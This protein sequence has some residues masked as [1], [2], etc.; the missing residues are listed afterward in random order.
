MKFDPKSA[1]DLIPDGEYDAEIASAEERQSKSGKDMLKLTLKVWAGTGGPRIVFDY[2]VN[3]DSLWRLKQI[4]GVLGKKEL[5]ESGEMGAS[6]IEGESVRVSIKTQKDKSEKFGDRS[7]V[8]RYLPLVAGEQSRTPVPG[9]DD[10]IP[11]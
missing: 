11:F 8:A 4:A 3:P 5:F 7:V 10:D 9:T 6:E 2:I 1:Y